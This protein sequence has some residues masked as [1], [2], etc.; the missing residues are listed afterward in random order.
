MQEKQKL[1]QNNAAGKSGN[2]ARNW[3]KC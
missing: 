3:T 2:V 1:R